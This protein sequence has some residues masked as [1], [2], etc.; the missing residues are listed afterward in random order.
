M[1]AKILA[2]QLSKYATLLVHKDQVGFVSRRQASNGTRRIVD[3]IQQAK[4]H[5]TPSLLLSLDAEKVF[6]RGLL[7][8]TVIAAYYIW[9]LS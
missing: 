6:D 8:L 1:Y 5:N 3:L 9:L 4:Q 7:D 2:T